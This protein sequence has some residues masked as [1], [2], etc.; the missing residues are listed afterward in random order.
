MSTES[1]ETSRMLEKYRLFAQATESDLL[2]KKEFVEPVYSKLKSFAQSAASTTDYRFELHVVYDNR[3]ERRNWHRKDHSQPLFD[4]VEYTLQE[5]FGAQ[6]ERVQPIRRDGFVEPDVWDVAIEVSAKGSELKNLETIL[7]IVTGSIHYHHADQSV[8]IIRD[9]KTGK[10]VTELH[11]GE[12][13]YYKWV[14]GDRKLLT[15]L[16]KMGFPKLP[17]PKVP[18]SGRTTAKNPRQLELIKQLTQDYL[19][20]TAAE[21]VL[22]KDFG[23]AL[24][25][26]ERI[27]P[28][29]KETHQAWRI[30][31][32]D[33]EILREFFGEIDSSQEIGESLYRMVERHNAF[34]FYPA[35]KK[36]GIRHKLVREYDRPR[37]MPME[38]AGEISDV[39]HRTTNELGIPSLYAYSGS[40]SARDQTFIDVDDLIEKADSIVKRYPFLAGLSKRKLSFKFDYYNCIIRALE[41][42]VNMKVAEELDEQNML[43]KTMRK[44]WQ[45]NVLNEYEQVPKTVPT[46]TFSRESRTRPLSLLVDS[47]TTCSIGIGSPKAYL[48]LT[49]E[50]RRA[51]ADV[52]IRYANINLPL[53]LLICI[54]ITAAP[55]S[56]EEKWKACNMY[57]AMETLQEPGEVLRRMDEKITAET[58]TAVFAETIGNFR[59]QGKLRDMRK[60]RGTREMEFF[61]RYHR[62]KQEIK[63]EKS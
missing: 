28:E 47:A 60:F 49:D 44:V 27:S 17:M 3:A 59:Q 46:V 21:S 1:F 5:F 33:E 20:R 43:W 48:E 2:R 15:D 36:N 62:P 51:L 39:I 54:P 19:S 38:V 10:L 52:D 14:L 63:E 16:E 23:G 50:R 58:V 57:S 9:K 22:R 32:S 61:K 6:V 42:C 18:F 25:A 24:V 55:R 13:Q 37:A 12:G 26:Y 56:T 29:G 7:D 11:G 53:T 31:Y 40:N 35:V 30:T 45:R 41:L 34:A 4:H 8:Y